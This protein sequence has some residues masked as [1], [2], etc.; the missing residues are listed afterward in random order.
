MRRIIVGTT[1]TNENYNADCD[2]GV[3][4]VTFTT[5][6]KHT[7]IYITTEA[8]LLEELIVRRVAWSHI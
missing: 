3:I 6:T 8:I 4:K 5:I 7:D 2:L 1:N